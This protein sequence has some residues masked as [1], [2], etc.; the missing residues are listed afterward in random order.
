MSIDL[1]DPSLSRRA[2]LASSGGLGAVAV[3][4]SGPSAVAL[5]L[6]SDRARFLSNPEL[7]TLRG[8]VDRIVPGKPEDTVD[9]AVAGRVHEAIDALLAAFDTDPP[10]I[11]AGGPFST[12]G[13]A[14]VNHFARFIDL[15]RYEHLA[16][17]LRIH[18][19]R[20][21]KQLER[22]GSHVGLR[23]VYRRGLRALAASVPG[24]ASLPGVARELALRS[25]QNAAVVAMLDVAVPHTLEFLFGAPEYGGNHRQAGWRAIGFDGDVQPRGYTRREVT[26]PETEL[27]PILDVPL[28]ELL[29]DAMPMLPLATSE[30]M[31]GIRARSDGSYAAGRAEVRAL[32]DAVSKGLKDPASDLGALDQLA[33][34]IV[35]AVQ[36]GERP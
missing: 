32:V 7:A 25:S 26:D 34:K 12:R 35:L 36:A 23:D 24:F 10:R 21:R 27:L 20:G 30:A 31:L 5:P 9:G 2:L 17:R 18:G 28:S 29:G 3:L 19:S 16:W 22:N 1:P 33:R 15:D 11:Y 13:G 8:V 4:G 6:G 14:E